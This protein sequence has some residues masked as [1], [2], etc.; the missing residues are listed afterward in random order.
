LFRH[1]TVLQ[2][3][4]ESNLQALRHAIVSQAL[5][6]TV[7]NGMV[8]KGQRVEDGARNPQP[9]ANNPHTGGFRRPV[10]NLVGLGFESTGVHNPDSNALARC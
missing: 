8:F 10:V 2:V 6:P 1:G 3:P 7:V 5:N 4:F 9:S